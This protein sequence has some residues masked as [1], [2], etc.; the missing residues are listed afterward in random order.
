VSAVCGRGR[1]G[2]VAGW[3]AVGRRAQ[4]LGNRADS[5][6]GGSGEL[7]GG[8]GGRAGAPAGSLHSWYGGIPVRCALRAAPRAPAA[9][10]EGGRV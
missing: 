7:E 4:L 2:R 5:G 6:R 10:F 3:A 1:A 9:P 8:G